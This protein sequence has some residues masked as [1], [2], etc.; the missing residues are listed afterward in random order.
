MLSV[1]LECIKYIE[2]QMI[3]NLLSELFILSD[4]TDPATPHLPLSVKCSTLYELLK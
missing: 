2:F 1:L 4:N 3:G